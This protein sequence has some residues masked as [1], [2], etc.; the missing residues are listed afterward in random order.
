MHEFFE[1]LGLVAAKLLN[2][3]LLLLF[4]DVGILLRLRSAGQTL[5][6]E[7]AAQKVQ[8]HVPNCLKVIT[9]G[10]LVT[11]MRVDGGIA[12]SSS[13]VLAVSE[14]NVLSIG[15]LEALG[16]AEVNNVDSVLGLIVA[17]DQEVVWLD[18]TVDNAFFVY[19]LDALDHLDGDVQDCLEVKLS[20]ALLEQ[21]F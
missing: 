5:P 3:R 21:I 17:T 2:R 19:N 1:L 6:R 4:L 20:A 18:V 15:R 8:D 11:K 9:A 7:R 14:R 13:Q 10:L 16:E 12:S